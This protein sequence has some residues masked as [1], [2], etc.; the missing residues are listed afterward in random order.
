LLENQVDRCPGIDFTSLRLTV[1][2]DY[3]PLFVSSSLIL[4]V[5][6]NFLVDERLF[7]RIRVVEGIVHSIYG[8]KRP[9]SVFDIK[10]RRRGASVLLVSDETLH[11][12]QG[13]VALQNHLDDRSVLEH[14]IMRVLELLLLTRGQRLV[15][16]KVMLVQ[17]VD[18]LLGVMLN[19]LQI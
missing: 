17:M 4:G 19:D 14:L 6:Q 3:L 2:G 8:I 5:E 18:L 10:L 11:L 16:L 1:F 15:K 12:C 13:V 9:Q 7:D